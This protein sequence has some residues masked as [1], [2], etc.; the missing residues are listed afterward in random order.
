MGT[1]GLKKVIL[2]TVATWE[3]IDDYLLMLARFE[4][5]GGSD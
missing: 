5:D 2:I 4:V 1:Q 3:K